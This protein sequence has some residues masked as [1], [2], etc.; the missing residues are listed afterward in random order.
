[1]WAAVPLHPAYTTHGLLLF[2]WA[3]GI[4]DG[5]YVVVAMHAC[6]GFF[7]VGFA[8]GAYWWSGF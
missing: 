2:V 6:S 8:A 5:R 1:M 7:A 3:S 4:I